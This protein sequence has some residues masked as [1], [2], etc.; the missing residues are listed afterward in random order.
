MACPVTPKA[1]FKADD[2]TTL[3]NQQRCI[4]CRLCQD[5]CPYSQYVLDE[6]SY[7]GD[8][9][10]VISFNIHGRPTYPEWRDAREL[11]PGCTASPAEVAKKT[12]ATPPDANMYESGD[13]KPVRSDGVVEKCIFC[14]PGPSGPKPRTSFSSITP[15]CFSDPSISWPS[16]TGR[17]TSTARR[18]SWE[19][20]PCRPSPCTG[21]AGSR[22]LTISVRCPIMSLWSWNF[23]TCCHSASARQ[24]MRKSEIASKKTKA[25]TTARCAAGER[26]S[27]E[28]IVFGLGT[29]E[30]IVIL[31]LVL[32]IFGAGKLPHVGGALGQGIRN[33]KKGIKDEQ[34]DMTPEIE[35]KKVPDDK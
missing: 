11:I 13:Y 2:N 8:S 28:T 32:V 23:S 18:S 12:G 22:W 29:Q 25:L 14:H 7:R 24:G 6:S 26:S 27:K 9:Y 20:Q 4:G 34:D 1:M 30:L 31:V 15:G 19:I 10:S 35:G 33:F 3:H 16:H 5:A 17:F 21:K